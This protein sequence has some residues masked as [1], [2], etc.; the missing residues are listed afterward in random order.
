[1]VES[2]FF[3]RREV[4]PRHG[5]E[6]KRELTESAKKLPKIPPSFVHEV[7]PEAR[8][9]GTTSSGGQ[10]REGMLFHRSR[11]GTVFMLNEPG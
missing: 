11:P 5:L 4:P 10:L 9:Q 2:R 8:N 7:A 6:R 1:M 3:R